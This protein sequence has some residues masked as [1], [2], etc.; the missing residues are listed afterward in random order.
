MVCLYIWLCKL[1][2]FGYLKICLVGFWLHFEAF[3]LSVST[4]DHR[5]PPGLLSAFYDNRNC[6]DRCLFVVSSIKHLMLFIWDFWFT[7]L[8][9]C[10]DEIF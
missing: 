3:S 7:F 10:L 8:F 1:F 4:T 2:N 6:S 9:G 5:P